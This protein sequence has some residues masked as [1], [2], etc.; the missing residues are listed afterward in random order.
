MEAPWITLVSV[1]YSIQKRQLTGICLWQ[2]E[3]HCQKKR[4]KNT[5]A[6]LTVVGAAWIKILET[7]TLSGQTSKKEVFH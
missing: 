6:F 7:E 4:L 5:V 1:E 2:K 3:E